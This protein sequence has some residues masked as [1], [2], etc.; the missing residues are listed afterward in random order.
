MC[1]RFTR[2]DRAHGDKQICLMSVG[3]YALDQLNE[4]VINLD[5]RNDE[6]ISELWLSQRMAGKIF[7][8][9]GY[10]AIMVATIVECVVI[11]A[12]SLL[13]IVPSCVL[14]CCIGDIVSPVLASAFVAIIEPLE[15]S[16]LCISGLVQN[17]LMGQRKNFDELSVYSICSDP[18]EAFQYEKWL[19]GLH[20][21]EAEEERLRL[22]H[23]E[24]EPVR[25]GAK[26]RA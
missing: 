19:V 14:S 16:L 17:I 12:L 5:K 26:S 8:V 11:L 20:A 25:A 10:A 1:L 2:D 4:F 22:L 13:A 3:P 15:I 18:S 9:L 24:P 21:R 23:P 7:G 6:G